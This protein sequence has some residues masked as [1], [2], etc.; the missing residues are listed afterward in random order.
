MF[1]GG[2]D[3]DGVVRLTGLVESVSVLISCCCVVLL[4]KEPVRVFLGGFGGALG[5]L[6]SGVFGFVFFLVEAADTVLNSV[7]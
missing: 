1:G 7:D 6:G 4:L 3:H 2:V 5:L